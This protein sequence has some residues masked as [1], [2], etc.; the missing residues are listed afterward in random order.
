MS[1][2][3]GGL[4]LEQLDAFDRGLRA[5]VPGPELSRAFLMLCF[6]GETFPEC[7]LEQGFKKKNTNRQVK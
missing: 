2:T 6:E 3:A 5:V 1:K 7:N 4:L